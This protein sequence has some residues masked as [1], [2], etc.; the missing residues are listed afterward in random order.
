MKQLLDNLIQA[1]EWAGFTEKGELYTIPEILTQLKGRTYS[2]E[3]SVAYVLRH[4]NKDKR[5][6]FISRFQAFA[7]K[8]RELATYSH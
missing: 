5:A 8:K 7:K 4:R 1:G 2:F 3:A 6:R